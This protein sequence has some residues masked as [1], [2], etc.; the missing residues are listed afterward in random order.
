MLRAYREKQQI[1]LNFIVFGL[2]Q[3]ELEPT[4]QPHSR[5]ARYLKSVNHKVVM[6]KTNRPRRLYFTIFFNLLFPYF[7]IF[8]IKLCFLVACFQRRISLFSCTTLSISMYRIDNMRQATYLKDEVLKFQE[9][10]DPYTLASPDP[11][12]NNFDD[13]DI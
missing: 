7:P 1:P 9:Y 10:D 4:N 2:T 3:S 11:I 13:I 12:T 6:W 8:L 5:R